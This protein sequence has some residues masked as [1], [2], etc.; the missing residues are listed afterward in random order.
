MMEELRF[1]VRCY[2]STKKPRLRRRCSQCVVHRGSDLYCAAAVDDLSPNGALQ[3]QPAPR[4]PVRRMSSGHFAQTTTTTGC[5]DHKDARFR[6]GDVIDHYND[7]I[8]VDANGADSCVKDG[9][10]K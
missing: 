8:P 9:L 1:A 10:R 4:P 6:Y 3:H 7:V 2:G 5:G